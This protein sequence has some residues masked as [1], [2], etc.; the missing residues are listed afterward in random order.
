MEIFWWLASGV[1]TIIA[2]VLA[3]RSRRWRYIGRAAVG[4]LFLLGGALVNASYLASGVDYAGFADTA[5]F[6]WVTDAWRAVVAPNVVP[7][8]SLL[9]V[10]E[11][12]VGALIL[13]GGRRTQL[14]YV[15]VIGF[16]LAL[17]LFGGFQLGWVVIMLP[18]MVLLLAVER[19]AAPA[20]AAH[21]E[22]QP[23]T[24]VGS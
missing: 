5:H 22:E 8:I 18:A 23:L 10:F 7:W 11:A 16:Y 1:A 13:S 15:G 9:V 3:S 17:W 14:G 24:G 6:G 21:L 12:T 19:R 20:P 4:V 2:A